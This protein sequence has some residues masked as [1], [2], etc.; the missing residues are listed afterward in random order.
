M[1]ASFQRNVLRFTGHGFIQKTASNFCQRAGSKSII[2]HQDG[3][4]GNESAQLRQDVK[5]RPIILGERLSGKGENGSERQDRIMDI[6]GNVRPFFHDPRQKK[7]E[8][9]QRTERG[10]E[11]DVWENVKKI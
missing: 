5:N 4:C 9:A 10:Q 3:K 11:Q 8:A 2:R 1:E 6:S 7:R